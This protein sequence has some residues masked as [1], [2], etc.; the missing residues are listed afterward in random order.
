MSILHGEKSSCSSSVVTQVRNSSAQ[1]I[2]QTNK[3][4]RNTAMN[5]YGIINGWR[6]VDTPQ[7]L[8]S[9]VAWSLKRL[10]MSLVAPK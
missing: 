2:T 7:N 10:T 8:K 1:R 4:Y 5:A 3:L 6:V 9:K